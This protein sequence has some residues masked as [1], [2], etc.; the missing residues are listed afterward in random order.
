M[1]AQQ[2][3]YR[4]L[5]AMLGTQSATGPMP[6][7]SRGASGPMF[8]NH[9]SPFPY[10]TRRQY[11]DG[12]P[13]QFVDMQQ[14]PSFMECP[15]PLVG[16]GQSS[17]GLYALP[18]S[19]FSLDPLALTL[20]FQALVYPQGHP[21][22]SQLS[23]VPGSTESDPTNDLFLPGSSRGPSASSS[24]TAP[25]LTPW[26][27]DIPPLH[28]SQDPHFCPDNSAVVMKQEDEDIHLSTPVKRYPIRRVR[29]DPRTSS[30]KYN[31]RH[32]GCLWRFRSTQ[33]CQRHER[34]HNAMNEYFCCNPNCSTNDSLKKD[35]VGFS[36][37]DSLKRH[38]TQKSSD[39]PCV[40]M[41]K[42]LGGPNF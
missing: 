2:T 16:H 40:V 38:Y 41:A 15:H 32:H 34:T 23:L 26:S 28:P 3:L 37:R 7:E 36:R 1:L 33:M 11:N 18:S 6:S 12:M 25:S 5:E 8:G 42:S 17:E 13:S 39:D 35:K 30:G 24:S 21:N 4:D 10:S 14:S 22:A 31:C 19:A 9:Y 29:S 27:S 20:Q